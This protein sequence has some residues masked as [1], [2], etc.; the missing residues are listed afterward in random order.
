MTGPGDDVPQP[1]NGEP[2][3]D[4][5]YYA[6]AGQPK[7]DEPPWSEPATPREP[8]PELVLTDKPNRKVLAALV[9]A[10]VVV[11]A[12]GVVAW[13]FAAGP[14]RTDVPRP[15]AQTRGNP[16]LPERHGPRS[17]SASPD[18]AAAYDVGSCFD[19]AQGAGPGKV[20]LNLVACGSDRAV[21]VINKVVVTSADCDA[22]ADFTDHGYEVPDET[23][24]VAYCAS[25]V[26]PANECFTLAAARP[27]KRTPC[28]ATPSTV[29]VT[30]VEPA[31]NVAA[32]C[33]DKTDPDVW[34]YQ[35]PESGQFAC[36]SRPPAT[37]GSGSATASRTVPTRTSSIT[38]TTG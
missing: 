21:F 1:W 5:P 10:V 9:V 7:A 19:E 36:V 16:A 8:A 22:A 25:L 33:T 34:F 30:A 38:P 6:E 15:V 4:P 27:V 2:P 23:A 26:V 3:T 29:R 12:G 11:V 35:S 18:L 31:P 13:W 20:E 37:T 17:G 28:D 14:G 32:A 24:N